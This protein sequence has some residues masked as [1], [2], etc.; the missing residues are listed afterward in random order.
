MTLAQDHEL[1]V[2]IRQKS[3]IIWIPLVHLKTRI[4]PWATSHL[5]NFTT[6][7]KKSFLDLFLNILS[8][9]KQD[10]FQPRDLHCLCQLGLLDWSPVCTI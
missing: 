9:I 4:S 7:V 6:E 8:Q 2:N 3:F 10:M 1:S 5:K